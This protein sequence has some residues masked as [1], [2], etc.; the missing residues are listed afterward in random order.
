[1]A[2]VL[3]ATCRKSDIITRWGGDEFA[4]ILPNTTEADVLKACSRIAACAAVHDSPIK[5]SIA[6]GVS[7]RTTMGEPMSRVIRTAEQWMYQHKLAESDSITNALVLSISDA[8]ETKYQDGVE[9]GARQ[10]TLAIKLGR[11]LGLSHQ[12]LADLALLARM[13]DVGHVLTKEEICP[14]QAPQLR[15]GTN[16]PAARRIRLSRARPFPSLGPLPKLFLPTM[17]TGTAA[18]IPGDW[19]AR[20]S[21]CWLELWPLWMPLMTCGRDAPPWV[22]CLQKRL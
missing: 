16:L 18:V 17:S 7:T 3:R 8:L 9:R 12:E 13:H 22:H 19:L 11:A 6:L 1:M 4:I 21:P 10:E 15:R 2:D 5:L 20:T 14:G